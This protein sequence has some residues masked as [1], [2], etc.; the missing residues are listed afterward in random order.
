MADPRVH[1]TTGETPPPP[2]S[3][4]SAATSPKYSGE[5]PTPP[6]PLPSKP[7]PP[8]ATYVVQFPKEQILRYPP[9]ENARKYQMYTRR[10]KRGTC[11]RRCCCF[12]LC[13]LVLLIVAAAISAGVLYLVF[14]F[15]APKYTVT[16]LAI[17]GVNLT[18]AVPVSPGFDVSI[19]AE[20]PNG[21][22][23]IYYL[24][25]SAVNVFHGDVLLSHGVLPNFYQPKK[26]TTVIQTELKGSGVVLGGTVKTALR[27]EQ[28]Q[29]RV[30][31]AVRIKAPVKI[32]VGSANTWKINVKVKCDVV[33]DTL[34]EKAKII[35][36]NCDYSVR[37]W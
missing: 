35:S 14:R 16:H 11:C 13:L 18:S 3:S 30:P 25:G 2:P 8:P 15:K 10:A 32:I 31:F 34:D 1:P 12:T 22:V 26:N 28:S 33:V 6:N 23:G 36:N 19:R 4:S 7:V 9:P 20:N 29:G 37:L 17:K 24:D 21:K 27:D 5:N